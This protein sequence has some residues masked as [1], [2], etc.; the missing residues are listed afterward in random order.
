MY[1]SIQSVVL[2]WPFCM[3]K[4]FMHTNFSTNVFH[5]C[6]AYKFDSSLVDLD[7]SKSQECRKAKTAAPNISQKFSVDLDGMWYTVE[8]YWCG[9]P[10][11]HFI[12]SI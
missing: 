10:L 5:T 3:A 7:H 4:T 2:G 12:S 11:T 8:T 6:F 9:E 1:R